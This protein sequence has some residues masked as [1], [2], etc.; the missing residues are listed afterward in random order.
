MTHEDDLKFLRMAIDCSR[1][2][3]IKG[4]FAAGA[5][6]VRDGVV[7]ATNVDSKSVALHEDSKA[8]ADAF[9]KYGALTGA[10]LYIGLESC[11]MC[12]C[13]G[14]WSGIRRVVYAI[15]KEK[16]SQSYYEIPGD[17]TAMIDSFNEKIE[18]IHIS[19]LEDEALS[20]VHEWEK[21]N[22]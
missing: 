15:R 12:T 19:E 20:I 21:N 13:V 9:Q 3:L 11:L 1:E 16:I 7:L 4:N 10:T 2:S 17:T 18:R 14:Y 5:V 8:I 6:V 22:S